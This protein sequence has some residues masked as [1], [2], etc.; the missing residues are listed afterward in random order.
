MRWLL[1][2]LVRSTLL[3]ALVGTA[4]LAGYGAFLVNALGLDRAEIER[5]A[6]SAA[7]IAIPAEAA[8]AP[9]DAQIVAPLAI[10]PEHIP[11]SVKAA[12]VTAEDRHFRWHFGVDPLAVGR[13]AASWLRAQAGDDGAV[14]TGGSTISMQLAKILF[15]RSDRTLKRKLDQ[16]VLALWLEWLFTKEE[17]LALYLNNAYFGDGRYGI[18]AAARHYFGRSVMKPPRID[19]I[20]A[21][22]LARTVRAPS[23][24]NPNR[25]RDRL[26]RSARALVGETA[27]RGRIEP[28]EAAALTVAGP[29]PRGPKAFR[30]APFHFRDE[31]LRQ[32]M[33]EG[34]RTVAEPLSLG[35]TLEP[36]TQLYAELAAAEALEKARPLGYDQVAI[37]VMRPDGAI[38]ALVGGAD[39]AA[40]DGFDIAFDGSRSPGSTLKPFVYLCA[41]E[42]GKSG[43]SPVVDEPRAFAA[44]WTPRNH[45]GRW[46]GR[47]SLEEALIQ[48]RNG[49]AVA[50]LQSCGFE[51][52][53]EI[54]RRVGITAAMPEKLTIA[55]GSAPVPLVQLTAAYAGLANGGRRVSPY[56]IWYARRPG[57]RVVY[58][59]DAAK[60]TAAAPAIDRHHFC[61]LTRMLR[62]ALTAGTGKNAAFAHPAAGKTGTSS[63]YR[64]ALFVG[65]SAH[66]AVGVWLGATGRGEVTGPVT[67]GGL[68]ALAFRRIMANLH[69]GK[70]V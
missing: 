23:L 39:Y 27:R 70:P 51:R 55:L 33:P 6:A 19:V 63:G 17:I 24:V 58:R 45:D 12:F 69:V 65:F 16:I 10:G 11:D 3:L 56:A 36:E 38:A 31:A 66:Y 64:D 22:M 60:D 47:I 9:F 30:I 1:R 52:F 4:L 20:E 18:E 15:L 34:L 42:N 57:G 8:R 43:A 61:A 41:L 68:P 67:G 5:R 59:H 13:A 26:E 28:E 49:P 40:L 46:L 48:S 25:N 32:L 62:G 44:G 54:L 29:R 37:V 2:R 50:E 35:L 53:T 14:V 7:T 21:A